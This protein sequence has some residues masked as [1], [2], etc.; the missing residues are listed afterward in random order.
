MSVRAETMLPGDKKTEVGMDFPFSLVFE[1][2]ETLCQGERIEKGSKGT[3]QRHESSQLRSLRRVHLDMINRLS[4]MKLFF[5][6]SRLQVSLVSNILGNPFQ[7]VLQ[8]IVLN[9]DEHPSKM[10]HLFACQTHV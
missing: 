8:V 4:H 3:K 6:S 2:K 10:S 7:C 9:T 1:L 5:F